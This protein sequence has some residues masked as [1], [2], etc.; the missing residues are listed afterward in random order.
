MLLRSKWLILGISLGL[1]AA[2]VPPI[3]LFLKPRYEST[4]VI[5]V[6][7][8]VSRIVF[9]TEDNGIVPLYQSYLNTQVSIIRGPTILNRVLDQPWIRGTRWYR[10]EGRSW[11]REPAPPLER[12][13]DG[14]AVQ[15]RPQTELIGV[16]LSTLVP[17]E[18]KQI[19]DAV[20]DEY[21]KSVDETARSQDAELMGILRS[22]FSERQRRIDGL[23]ET[24]FTLSKQAGAVDP[25]QLRSQLSTD[26]SRLES[27]RSAVERSLA[28]AQYQLERLTPASRPSSSA[29]SGMTEMPPTTAPS[30]AYASDPEWL[31]L[32]REV[33]S[34]QHALENAKEVYGERHT[35]MK[36][37]QGDLEFSQRLLKERETQLDI[38]GITPANSTSP[39]TGDTPLAHDRRGLEAKI[40]EYERTLELLAKEIEGQQ[41]KVTQVGEIAQQIAVVEE[42]IRQNREINDDVRQRI[43]EK[44]MESKAPARIQISSYGM[45]PSEPAKDQRILLTLL[46]VAGAV[47]VGAGVGYLRCSTDTR[48]QNVGDLTDAVQVPF[49]G[50]LLMLPR[51]TEPLDEHS[52]ALDEG[53]RMIRT[54]LVRRLRDTR[55]P[56]VLITSPL[57]QSGKTTMAVL[58]ARSL[59]LLKKR[60]LLIEADLRRPSLAGRLR[61]DAP[62]GLAAILA[63]AATD[64]DAILRSSDLKIDILTAGNRPTDFAPDSLADT[65]F[66]DCLERWKKSYDFVILDGPPVLPVADSRILASQADG[67]V[68]VLKSSH[69]RRADAAQAYACLGMAGGT[70]L[71]TVLVGGRGEGSDGYYYYGS[72]YQLSSHVE[73]QATSVMA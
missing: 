44:E 16:S 45:V 53:T 49:L 65:A 64:E 24:K 15:P 62:L 33:T 37:L 51:V 4:A 1:S 20:A 40:H 3:W 68:M 13:R 52:P 54:A 41:A 27:E 59:A 69:C 8:V 50:H 17:G 7:P 6:A 43:E 10:E 11:L 5:R 22:D 38:Q 32:N 60:V 14:L 29:P 63:G 26:L 67:T 46:A 56:V 70:L 58:L 12:L 30:L 2:A 31:R 47:A 9:K 36:Q 55:A 18:A 23:I 28:I 57:S 21:K 34:A 39:A 25:D 35:R 72:D 48:I 73:E 42:Q 66:S 61:I 19:V 71:G